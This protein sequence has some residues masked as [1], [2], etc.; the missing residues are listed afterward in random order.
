MACKGQFGN[1]ECQT[2]GQRIERLISHGACH[3]KE[4]LT[5]LNNWYP[6]RNAR[7]SDCAWICSDERNWCKH[8]QFS[9]SSS[10]SCALYD[11]VPG[12]S[13]ARAKLAVASEFPGQ[14]GACNPNSDSWVDDEDYDVVWRDEFDVPG[15]VD[16]SK[17][18]AVH[19]GGG[20]WNNELQFYS[21]REKNAWISDGTLK[22]RAV[23]ENYDGHKYTSAKLESKVEWTYGKFHVRARL[24]K[25][26]ARGTWPAHWMMPRASA[27][28]NWPRSGEI[29]IM[30]HVGYNSGKVHGTV[31]T[32]A[33]NHR[34][35]TQMGGSMNVNVAD[36]HTY[37]VDWRTDVIMFS[38]DGKVYNTFR[39]QSNDPAKWPFN[40]A[41]YLILNMAV[42]GNWG[43]VKGVDENSFRG[44][45]Q[46]MEIDWVRVEQKKSKDVPGPISAPTFAPTSAPLPS[47]GCC[48]NKSGD[49]CKDC[50]NDGSG[51]CH[52]S[53]SNCGQCNGRFDSAAPSP[54]CSTSRGCCRT[55]GGTCK[56]CGNDGSGWCHKSVSNCG[57]CKGQF[58]SSAL[59]PICS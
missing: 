11:C 40:K 24:N 45:G 21:N 17:W 3:A 20:F 18:S 26:T 32:S 42:G 35:G 29:D 28:G 50:G 5:G 30:E 23:R 33:Y 51:W 59:A 43:G 36:W 38:C 19:K 44:E 39:K 56:D 6:N 27:Y 57:Q 52:N 12:E 1:E 53:A 41:F 54:G 49:S 48:K 7:E 4:T 16:Q 9:T 13:E 46:I 37:T 47:R 2:C 31:H 58:D 34:I 55:I 10:G 8:S 14:C 15:K 22:I 25:G